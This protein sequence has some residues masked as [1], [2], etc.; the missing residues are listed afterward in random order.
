MKNTLKDKFKNNLLVKPLYRK[1]KDKNKVE[2]TVLI[3]VD[4]TFKLDGHA[5]TVKRN[6]VNDNE[7]SVSNKERTPNRVFRCVPRDRSNHSDLYEKVNHKYKSNV[8]RK[9]NKML[10]G[11]ENKKPSEVDGID[12]K[13]NKLVQADN[14]MLVNQSVSKTIQVNRECIKDKY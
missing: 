2:P 12:D 3:S 11:M 6:I 4:R 13:T 7:N 9:T 10:S 14:L 5:V 8:L 1:L